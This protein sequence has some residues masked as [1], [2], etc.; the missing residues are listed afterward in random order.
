MKYIFLHFILILIFN[1][2]SFFF[3]L[4]STQPNRYLS[5]TTSLPK[6]HNQLNKLFHEKKCNKTNCSNFISYKI[7]QFN[8]HHKFIIVL[9]FY[10]ALLDHLKGIVTCGQKLDEANIMLFFCFFILNRI[11]MPYELKEIYKTCRP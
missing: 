3:L 10:P 2:F 4:F 7:L 9:D 8:A 11:C 6:L 1:F 5:Y